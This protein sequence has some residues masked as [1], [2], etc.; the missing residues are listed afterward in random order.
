MVSEK[1]EKICNFSKKNAIINIVFCGILPRN[2]KNESIF[3]QNEANNAKFEHFQILCEMR[4]LLKNTFQ[5]HFYTFWALSFVANCSN[6]T[7]QS[8]AKRN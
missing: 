5:K 8:G 2:E 1:H 3:F 4:A 6:I 7:N